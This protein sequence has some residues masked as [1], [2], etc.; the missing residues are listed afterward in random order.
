MAGQVLLAVAQA[1]S[2]L[3]TFL[4]ASL[5]ACIYIPY[6]I[7][8][9]IMDAFRS[10]VFAEE[11]RRGEAFAGSSS[12]YLSTV[13]HS[14]SKP[15]Q[16][17]F[18]YDVRICVLDLDNPPRWWG[19]EGALRNDTM[20]GDEARQLANTQG[21]VK[22]LTHA[23]V[24]GYRQNPIS[25]YY[26]YNRA[27]ELEICIAEVTNTP[28]AERVVFLFRPDGETV[29]KSLHV[30]P[31]MDMENTWTL[32]T[33]DPNEKIFLSVEVDHP[34]KGR[35]F[36]AVMKG[37]IDPD[38]PH[39]PNERS[40]LGNLFKYGF[41]PQRIALWIYWHAL[42][43]LW[44]GVPFYGP[45]SLHLCKERSKAAANPKCGFQWRP[46]QEWPWRTQEGCT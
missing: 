39:R 15:V 2:V 20:T 14:R 17:G 46:A 41:Q 10:M 28:W 38:N 11:R 27:D 23:P 40:G 1:S 4:F 8:L 22:L 31:L 26:C 44:K 35:Y 3:C 42:V 9:N 5:N 29:P 24:A 21:K 43:L 37:V 13:Y 30:S 25:V 34:T 33:H 19:A 7:L 36:S 6:F 32:K 16:H 12:M 18:S 45:P